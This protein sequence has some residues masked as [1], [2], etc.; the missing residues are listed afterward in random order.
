MPRLE[1]LPVPL[2]GVE[3]EIIMGRYGKCCGG[4]LGEVM[5]KPLSEVLRNFLFR[6]LVSSPADEALDVM[7]DEIE[8][9]RIFSAPCGKKL[10]S[11]LSL[12][13]WNLLRLEFE[14][15]WDGVTGETDFARDETVFDGAGM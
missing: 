13:V 4:D 2:W 5:A 12:S 6:G 15:E 14:L 11:G 7:S 1:E 10:S 9:R 8:A 3:T